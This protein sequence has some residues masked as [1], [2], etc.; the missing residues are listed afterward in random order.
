MKKG[1]INVNIILFLYFCSHIIT[2]LGY[3]IYFYDPSLLLWVNSLLLL[4]LLLIPIFLYRFIFSITTTSASERF[5][6]YHYLAPIILSLMMFLLTITTPVKEQLLTITGNGLYKGHSILFY[7]FS[8]KMYFRLVFSIRY[9][10]L[11]FR[12]LPRYRKYIINYSANQAKS[13]LRWVNILLL[14]MLGLSMFPLYGLFVSR[15]AL[16]TSAVTYIQ[17]G[18]LILQ[19][20]Y[21]TFHTTKQ[22]YILQ[23]SRTPV[24]SEHLEES[25]ELRA[26]ENLCESGQPSGLVEPG[27]PE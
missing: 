6:K 15:S 5:S 23:E 17:T 14:F 20:A 22:H 25:G 18:F 4:T 8:N 16:A 9:I 26:P 13:S 11:S 27:G 1:S 3:L 7:I 12:R 10:I 21:L 19:F 2:N 24:Q